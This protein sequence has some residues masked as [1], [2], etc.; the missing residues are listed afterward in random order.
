MLLK[1]VLDSRNSTLLSVDGEKNLHWWEV[2]NLGL[3]NIKDY[4]HN[5]TRSYFD[6]R[7]HWGTESGFEVKDNQVICPWDYALSMP[8]QEFISLENPALAFL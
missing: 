8:V 5:E 7:T 4:L 3:S 6:V 1:V 2:N